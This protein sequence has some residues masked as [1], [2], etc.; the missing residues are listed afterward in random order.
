MRIRQRRVP[1]CRHGRL[2][3]RGGSHGSSH[4][5]DPRARGMSPASRSTRGAWTRNG[6]RVWVTR[7]LILFIRGVFL[8]HSQNPDQAYRQ[9][10]RVLKRDGRFTLS[11]FIT[12]R[13]SDITSGACSICSSR[14][15]FSGGIIFRPC[16]DFTRTATIIATTPRANF[17]MPSKAAGLEV[18]STEV[19]HMSSKM[20]PGDSRIPAEAAKGKRRLAIG[21]PWQKAAWSALFRPFGQRK[22]L[23][24]A[25]SSVTPPWRY[26][27]FI[28]SDVVDQRTGQRVGRAFFFGWK[29]AASSSQALIAAY[30]QDREPAGRC[31]W[32]R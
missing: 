29:Q 30:G 25:F 22:W 26:F 16:S 19:T 4:R 20:I 7:H 23:T 3:H 18:E 10:A 13:A 28:G 27:R 15:G 14:G 17:A 21:R 5:V 24:C 11:W 31:G 1:V 12:S 6:W 32:G 9:V 8:H 2:G